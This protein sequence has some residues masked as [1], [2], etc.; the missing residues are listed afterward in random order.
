MFIRVS[1]WLCVFVCLWNDDKNET[2]ISC[3]IIFIIYFVWWH[4]GFYV[5]T[6]KMNIYCDIG[7]HVRVKFFRF[8]FQNFHC[9]S[10]M[11]RI[12]K[13][14]LQCRYQNG[15]LRSRVFFRLL[16]ITNISSNL[17]SVFFLLF[18]VSPINEISI[19]CIYCVCI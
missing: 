13:I 2:R 19:R 6:M 5:V 18:F 17:F 8:F 7:V 10:Q 9:S 15:K 1:V 3:C 4:T 14:Y 12:A 11:I 16:T